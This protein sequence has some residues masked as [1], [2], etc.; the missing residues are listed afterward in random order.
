MRYRALEAYTVMTNS[1]E[2][3]HCCELKYAQGVLSKPIKIGYNHVYYVQYTC[4]FVSIWSPVVS[5]MQLIWISIAVICILLHHFVCLLYVFIASCLLF[6]LLLSLF[7][8][9]NCSNQK[10]WKRM[11]LHRPLQKPLSHHFIIGCFILQ[12]LHIDICGQVEHHWEVWSFSNTYPL[13]LWRCYVPTFL[14][15]FCGVPCV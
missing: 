11:W 7:S 9:I 15:F 3:I 2:N 13:S 5:Q 10:P 14:C 12:W 6:H 8:F 4:V 1:L